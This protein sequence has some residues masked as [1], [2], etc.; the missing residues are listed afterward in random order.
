MSKSNVIRAWKDPAYRNSLSM[1]ERAGLPANPAG[2]IEISDAE[3][4]KTAG[5]RKP[6]RTEA[7][8]CPTQ[9]GCTVVSCTYQTACT[10]VFI[11]CLSLTI[12]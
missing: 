7:G 10:T 8:P 3:L 6:L 11:E 12:C 1:A 4:G 9:A 5:G 2:G